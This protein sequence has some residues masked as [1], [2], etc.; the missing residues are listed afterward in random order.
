[1]P[2]LEPL[3]ERRLDEPLA[4]RRLRELL[5]VLHSRLLRALDELPEHVRE[6]HAACCP[7]RRTACSWRRRTRRAHRLD[8]SGVN[9]SLLL[10]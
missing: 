2:L 7:R 4:H 9:R 3:P 1:M 8:H 5:H 10:E 6:V